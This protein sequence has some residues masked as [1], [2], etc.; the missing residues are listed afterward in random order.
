MHAIKVLVTKVPKRQKR[1]L[2]G[3]PFALI[4][5]LCLG[6]FLI[7]TPA[8]AGSATDITGTNV[9]NSTAPI[10]APGG[11]RIDPQ[12]IERARRLNQEA[13]QAFKDCDAAVLAA[14]Q[15]SRGPRQF[16][17]NPE[18]AEAEYPQACQRLNQLRE[19]AVSLRNQLE[20]AG[21]SGGNAA[22]RTW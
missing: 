15:S 19:E 16:L 4:P 17:R 21:R 12:L 14:Q 20:E 18:N 6:V 11:G 10:F 9:W 1:V 22:Y 7:P 5:S 2:F 13:D 8:K 3:L